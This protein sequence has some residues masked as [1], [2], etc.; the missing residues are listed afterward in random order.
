MLALEL[1]HEIR[2]PLE[3][4]GHLVYLAEKVADDPE[5][6]R[7]YMQAAEEHMATLNRIA[8]QTLGF[9]RISQHPRPIDLMDLAEAALRIHQRTVEAKKIHL[10]KKLPKGL[11]AK[12]HSGQMLQV[13][14]NLLV[15][16]LEALPEAGTLSVRLR[17]GPDGFH[18]L[19]ADNGHGIKQ[20]H[21]ERVFEPFFTTRDDTGNG[22]GL[23]LSRKVIEEHGGKIR[24]R[25][26]VREGRQ[27]TVFKI[28]LPLPD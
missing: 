6:V 18:L 10:V 22:L 5:L 1:M 26:S 19:V 12:V 7:K 28:S 13:V 14:S 8:S 27:G 16:A 24:L 4:V 2:N 23:S 9:A 25:S 20:E 11:L 3:A 15:N 21:L 17:K